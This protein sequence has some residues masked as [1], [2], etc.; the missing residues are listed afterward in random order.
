MRLKLRNMVLKS[1]SNDDIK[2][3]TKQRN[4]R[5]SLPRKTQKN[6]YRIIDGKKTLQKILM[7]DNEV[8]KTLH[9]FFFLKY[10]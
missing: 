7:N 9:D 1:G 4:L 6:Y 3:Y 8:L 10:Y 5:V 2:R